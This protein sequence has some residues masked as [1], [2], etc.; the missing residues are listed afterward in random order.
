M[1]V[2]GIGATIEDDRYFQIF[3]E[4]NIIFL[5]WEEKEAPEL[6]RLFKSIKIGDIVYVKSY[7]QS[8]LYIKAIG[9][10]SDNELRNFSLT[11]KIFVPMSTKG[12]FRR[13]CISIKWVW[14]ESETENKAIHLIPNMDKYNVRNVA[15]Y[16]EFSKNVLDRVIDKIVKDI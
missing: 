4:H 11:D 6:Y 16:E 13:K 3:I 5:S 9:I 15:I 8:G 7:N 2:Y 1:A 14:D 12:K 10:V